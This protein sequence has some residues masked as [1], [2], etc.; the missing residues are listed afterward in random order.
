MT[1]LQALKDAIAAHAIAETAFLDH[2]REMPEGIPE[3]PER[4][5][6]HARLQARVREAETVVTLARE[7]LAG[8]DCPRPFVLKEGPCWYST[9][10]AIGIENALAIAREGVDPFDYDTP[11]DTLYIDVHVEC[12]LTGESGMDTVTFAPEVPSCEEGKEHDWRSPFEVVGGLRESPGVVV[13]GGGVI[14]REVCAHCACYRVTETWAERPDTGEQGL[15]EVDYEDPDDS[16]LEWL[17]ERSS[18]A[19]AAW[20]AA[21]WLELEGLR[22]REGL[23]N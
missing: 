6:A 18:P 19:S 7:A 17:A 5:A 15:T 11:A 12:A 21:C 4:V 8:S 2:T 16:S 14:V 23:G 22:A 20:S 1:R 3:S 10:D 13:H 9:V